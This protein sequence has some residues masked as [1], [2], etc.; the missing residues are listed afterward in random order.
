MPVFRHYHY[1]GFNAIPVPPKRSVSRLAYRSAMPPSVLPASREVLPATQAHRPTLPHSTSRDLPPHV[2]TS[3][4]RPTAGRIKVGT[5]STVGCGRGRGG[6]ESGGGEG[7][8]RRR[9]RI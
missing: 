5:R 9:A 2:R 6:G 1:N 7:E 4:A 8:A 3:M